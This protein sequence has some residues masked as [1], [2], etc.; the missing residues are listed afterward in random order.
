MEILRPLALKLRTRLLNANISFSGNI[1]ICVGVHNI[2]SERRFFF[3]SSVDSYHTFIFKT[4]LEVNINGDIKFQMMMMGRSGYDKDW[5]L[6]CCYSK[7]QWIQHHLSNDFNKNWNKKFPLWTTQDIATEA[8]K[9]DLEIEGYIADV[10]TENQSVDK[11]KSSGVKEPCIWP[12]IPVTRHVLPIPHLLLGLGNK[13][14][15]H[16]WEFIHDRVEKLDNEVIQAQNVTIISCIALERVTLIYDEACSELE[17]I[18]EERVNFNKN[19]R[20]KLNEV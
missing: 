11:C 4:K 7:A 1:I 12:F 18:V 2:S 10:K 8:V 14:M 15:N 9:R 5:C 16:F 3:S 13:V 17:T 6:H 20:K 19:N